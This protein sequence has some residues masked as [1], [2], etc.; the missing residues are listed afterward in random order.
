M[1][2]T[3]EDKDGGKILHLPDMTDAIKEAYTHVVC[4]RDF[5]KTASCIAQFAESIV[6][7]AQ[8]GGS[9]ANL[10]YIAPWDFPDPEEI[11][12]KDA[13]AQVTDYSGHLYIGPSDTERLNVAEAAT[14]VSWAYVN[15]EWALA[16]DLA[17]SADLIKKGTTKSGGCTDGPAEQDT[18]YCSNC[19]GDQ[20]GTTKGDAGDSRGKCVGV[21]IAIS[22]PFDF[23]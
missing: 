10:A 6:K 14:W 1:K 9:L 19:G 8:A 7:F 11:L 21:S 4:K 17:F 5:E 13:L 15:E 16:D 22:Y 2:P 20:A 3:T 23:Y 18:P 12:L